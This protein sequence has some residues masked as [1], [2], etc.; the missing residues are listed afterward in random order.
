MRLALAE[1]VSG[2]GDS[3]L[4]PLSVFERLDALVGET[5]LYDF[6]RLEPEE[7]Y[8]DAAGFVETVRREYYRELWEECSRAAGLVEEA[9]YDR[10]LSDYFHHVRAF[11]AG[12]KVKNP[13]SGQWEEPSEKLLE[14]VERHLE[15]DGEVAEF[16][17]NLVTKAAAWSL[18]H[19]GEKLDYATAFREIHDQLHRS[20]YAERRRAVR[21]V[22]SSLLRLGTGDQKSL[23]AGQKAK[24][25]N[26]MKGLQEA[27][28]CPRCAKEA[29][30]FLLRAEDQYGADEG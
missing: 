4:T 10:L 5:S 27:G 19:P 25:E 18:D 8:G 29:V 30:A 2:G 21:A 14:S 20:F 24:A 22:L 15:I 23:D 13:T 17:Q 28:Y 3:C 6:L 26:A 9:E 1:A 7:G 12:D 16:R 11:V